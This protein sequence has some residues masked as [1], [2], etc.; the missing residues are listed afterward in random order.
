MS[1]SAIGVRVIKLPKSGT[2]SEPEPQKTTYTSAST[3]HKNNKKRRTK[4]PAPQGTPRVHQESTKG[5]Q[6]VY[7]SKAE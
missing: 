4:I 6:M 5:P 2:K 1:G 3:K 7:L